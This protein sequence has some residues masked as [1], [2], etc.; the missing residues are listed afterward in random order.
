MT[1]VTAVAPGQEP[2][3]LDTAKAWLRVDADDHDT[4]ITALIAS[5]RARVE[6]YTRRRLITQSVDLRLD[7][8]GSGRTSGIVLPVAPVQSV[9]EVVYRDGAGVEQTLSS[10]VYRLILSRQPPE[11]YPAYGQSWPVPRDEADSVR[12][13][14]VVGYGDTAAAVPPDLLEATRRLIAW[15]YERTFDAEADTDALPMMVRSLLD[16]HVFWI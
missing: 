16:P 11:L 9:T 13:R 2:V 7:A 8:F 12:V 14:L 15:M 4:M 10:G 1:L 5:A 3:D 6:S